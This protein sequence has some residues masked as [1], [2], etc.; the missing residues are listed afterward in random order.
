[1]QQ[2]TKAELR[3]MQILWQIKRGVVNDILGQMGSPK[4]AYNTVSTIVRILER[5]GFIDHKSY[6][7]THE[8]YPAVDKSDYSNFYL[9][10]FINDF[11]DGS[12]KNLV[13]F[14]SKENDVDVKDLEEILKQMDKR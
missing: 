13:S 12:F 11:F 9:T 1:M 2:L 3:V 8:Y 14:F 10:I 5:K 7:K 4:P 6:G